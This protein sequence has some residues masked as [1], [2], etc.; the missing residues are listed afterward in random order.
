MN[1]AAPT[2]ASIMPTAPAMT[3]RSSTRLPLRKPA[4]GLPRPMPRA[5]VPT[6]TLV[7]SSSHRG[8]WL[9]PSMY[10][11]ARMNATTKVKKAIPISATRNAL[12]LNKVFSDCTIG[13]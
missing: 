13:A 9:S 12:V 6:T 3:N 10:T 1:S 7:L 5:T 8:T 4:S 2:S 11:A